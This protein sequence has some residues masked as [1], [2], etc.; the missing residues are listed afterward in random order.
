MV[1]NIKTLSNSVSYIPLYLA[2]VPVEGK[3]PK[4]KNW[5]NEPPLSHQ[6]L[7]SEL[8]NNKNYTGYGLRLGPISNG[9]VAVDI[10][11]EA[12]HQPY[13]EIFGTLPNKEPTTVKTTSGKP[14]RQAEYYLI[15]EQFWDAI[16][17]TKIKTGIVGPD[18]K[19]ELLELRWTGLQQVLPPS[20]HPDGGNYQYLPGC[21][22]SE[23]EIAP[24]PITLIEKMLKDA[25]P[26]I[27]IP[28]IPEDDTPAISLA[29]II[30]I[31]SRDILNGVQ[32]G[33]RN[34]TGAKL[35]RELIGAESSAKRLGINLSDTAEQLF[36]DFCQRCSPP[37]SN[38]ES[39][40]IW[41]S[42][43]KSNP[44][45]SL[46]DDAILN[47]VKAHQRK[48]NKSYGG[49][50]RTKY[51]QSNQLHEPEPLPMASN[52][53]PIGTP[54]R[55]LTI[56]DLTAELET[57][58]NSL[59]TSA[60]LEKG[61]I[62]LSVKFGLPIPAIRPLYSEI[63]KK[64]STESRDLKQDLA[65]YQKCLA[66]RLVNSKLFLPGPLRHVSTMCKNLGFLDEA[67]ILLL[68]TGI[69]AM[70]HA[71]TYL[72]VDDVLNFTVGPTIFSCLIAESGMK[73]SPLLRNIIKD[74]IRVLAKKE[75]KRYEKAM[76]DWELLSDDEKKS[77]PKPNRRC[78]MIN[79]GTSEGIRNLVA[80]NK[81]SGIL[82]FL[83]ELK[84]LW[85]QQGKYSNGIGDDRQQL[86]E[87]YDGYLPEVARASVD[88]NIAGTAEK[89][90]LP[91][92]GGI[93]PDIL[94]ELFLK[95][96][97]D[98][99][100]LMARFMFVTVPTAP[101]YIKPDRRK[102][103]DL[104]EYLE[105]LYR[106]ISE[107]RPQRHYLSDDAYKIFV[108]VYNSCEAQKMKGNPPAIQYQINKLPGKIAKIALVLHYLLS[109]VNN[110]DQPVP[111]MVEVRT[112][113]LAIDWGNYQINQCEAIYNSFDNSEI[114]P[115]LEKILA[116][117]PPTG[118]TAN[119]LKRAVWG[120]REKSISEINDLIQMLVE[121][122]HGHTETHNKGFRFFKS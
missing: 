71:D 49:K 85:S 51:K 15:P 100:G 65:E 37:L 122:G 106:R 69:S 66:V 68:I 88:G 24:A 54:R 25:T 99:D 111:E 73:K 90:N 63:E 32:A 117:T 95:D 30:N 58:A 26:K 56:E 47:C 42:A 75:N 7:I 8:E 119:Q 20:A 103:V 67:G 10:D 96:E 2:L 87:S 94:H 35:A 59:L 14:G 12:G 121:V 38:K 101:A 29:Q 33:S 48:H 43:D 91:V 40:S 110:P 114:A 61:F 77:N 82:R 72:V 104:L 34:D 27:P 108:E 45:A 19:E 70:I 5:A 46:P 11:G 113:Q 79:G 50:S 97:H 109:L 60:D 115:L 64:H 55:K 52:V 116:K 118:I 92:I 21:S 83:D 80:G 23:V 53:V 44:T 62:E 76:A 16:A 9:L 86:I 107:Q 57:M 41:I 1:R 120:L 17:T 13:Q 39:K 18:G 78:Y 22:F 93:Q 89:V 112:M 3:A 28:E 81:G 31:N 4:R 84:G 105:G 36:Y 6:Q 102:P 74:A 98:S